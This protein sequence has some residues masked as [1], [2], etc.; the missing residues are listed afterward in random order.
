MSAL[1][2][3]Q[4]LM[5]PLWPAKKLCPGAVARPVKILSTVNGELRAFGV[6]STEQRRDVLGSAMRPPGGARAVRNLH[7]DLFASW[8]SNREDGVS[9]VPLWRRI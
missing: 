3:M 1:Q 9:I 4:K 6:R 7:L 8:S 5:R 2:E